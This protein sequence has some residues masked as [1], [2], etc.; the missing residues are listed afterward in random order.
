[1][2]KA[3]I[4]NRV[5]I[6]LSN[7]AAVRGIYGVL[8]IGGVALAALGAMNLSELGC[9]VAALYF[10]LIVS[11]L[12]TIIVVCGRSLIRIIDA[13]L[14]GRRAMTEHSKTKIGEI[15][16]GVDNCRKNEHSPL[17]VVRKQVRRTI[18]FCCTLSLMTTVILLL[19]VVSSYGRAVPIMF[20]LP[21]NQSA[22]IWF[23]LNLLLHSRKPFRAR[24]RTVVVGYR[25]S[26]VTVSSKCMDY[27]AAH[28]N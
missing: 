8:S 21:L 20:V 25:A 1:M 17:V 18:I 3:F 9:E 10:V 4:I 13:C 19:A 14:E 26:A 16:D 6:F 24:A 28:P 7:P 2:K 11:I 22:T 27:T 5:Y 23:E 15:A 12:A